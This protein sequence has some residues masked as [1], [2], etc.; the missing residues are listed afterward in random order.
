A[1]DLRPF[2]G[3]AADI[4]ASTGMVG[5]EAS[6]W[7]GSSQAALSTAIWSSTGDVVVYDARYNIPLH[8][9]AE[10][11]QSWPLPPGTGP[12]LLHYHYLAE[13]EYQ[14]HLGP[15]LERLG[16]SADVQRWVDERLTWFRDDS[17]P[18]IAANA[19][20]ST[21]A[22][23]VCFCTLAIHAPYRERARQLIADLP[24]VPWLV[25]TDEPGDFADV[26]HLDVRAVAH[27][28]TG[29]MAI[30]YVERIR[31]TG[32]N[33]GAAAYHDKR[34]AL[35]HS[36]QHHD[37][38]IFL[39]ADS[40]FAAPPPP[41]AFPPGISV[42][43]L[44]QRSIAEHLQVA[45]TWRL[46]AFEALAEHLTGSTCI[47]HTAKWCHEACIA[48]TKDGREE[49][50]FD[51]WGRAAAFMQEREVYSGEGGVIGLAAELAGWTVDF[52]AAVSV[53]DAVLHEGG[54]PKPG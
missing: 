37:T 40:R 24:T 48:I 22:P 20:G 6:E 27:Q 14:Q 23:S 21:A 36:L 17:R 2:R 53:G 50:F 47:L 26:A 33:Q 54:G 11:D 15:V 19:G 3:H 42:L 52:E 4:K 10:P 49:V 1:D 43:P 34:F 38:A 18:A 45:G 46:P 30:D 16:C 28:P 7:W 25:L 31:P 39:D 12:V 41:R 13:P 35:Q 51:M 5:Q 29:P 9:L 32:N 8:S 44:V